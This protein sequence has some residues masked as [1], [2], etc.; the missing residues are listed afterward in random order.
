MSI[1]TNCRR[2][3]CENRKR[4]VPINTSVETNQSH[5]RIAINGLSKG[6]F[7]LHLACF[8]MNRSFHPFIFIAAHILSHTDTICFRSPSLIVNVS[9]SY[10]YCCIAVTISFVSIYII[11]IIHILIVVFVETVSLCRQH[12]V[13]PLFRSLILMV[14]F[15]FLT[16]SSFRMN[17]LFLSEL[18]LHVARVP[19]SFYPLPLDI[20]LRSFVRDLQ[21]RDTLYT[22]GNRPSWCR[23][24]SPLFFFTFFFS[25]F[26]CPRILERSNDSLP[27]FLRMQFA[28]KKRSIARNSIDAT[29]RNVTRDRISLTF[30]FMRKLSARGSLFGLERFR[31]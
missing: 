27:C 10:C 19:L 1:H 2:I 20:S 17:F 9:C 8:F 16:V 24:T 6:S 18:H 30:H 12:Q 22:T 5:R 23:G 3:R 26:F 15:L 31:D 28:M 14:V 4:V 29:R 21:P 11:R 25:L 13:V 7:L